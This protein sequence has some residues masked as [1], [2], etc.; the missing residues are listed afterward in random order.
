VTARQIVFPIDPRRALVMVRRD[1]PADEGRFPAGAEQ[2]TIINRHVAFTGHRFLVRMPGTNPLAGLSLPTKAPAV[3]EAHGALGVGA[4]ESVEAR[5]KL[6]R[7]IERE[8]RRGRPASR[9]R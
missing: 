3:F 2:A 6:V 9:S 4:S 8:T 7:R 5:V 1:L